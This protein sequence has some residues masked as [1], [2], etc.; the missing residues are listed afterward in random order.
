MIELKTIL[1][2]KVSADK[3]NEKLKNGGVISFVTDTV[4]GLGCLPNCKKAVERIYEIKGRDTSKPLILMSN[5]VYN[6]FPYVD[7][8]NEKARKL[9]DDYF[10][11]ALTLVLK[12][13][14]KTPL[15]IT[16]NKDTVGIRVPNNIFFKELCSIIDGGVLATTSANLSN[17]PSSKNYDEAVTSIGDFVDFVFE[18]NGYEAKGL[19]STVVLAVDND[20]K[21]LRQGEIIIHCI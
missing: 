3:L 9:M 7:S 1:N 5:S 14:E 10:P 20:I 8:I 18:D 11:G 21:V 2:K 12:K 4:W 13:S 15:Y 16:S 17:Y 19:E 6:L